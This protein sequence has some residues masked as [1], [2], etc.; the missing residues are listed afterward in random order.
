MKIKNSK[1]KKIKIK[2]TSPNIFG[3]LSSEGKQ[4]EWPDIW[5]GYNFYVKSNSCED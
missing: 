3:S 2:N 5:L 1:F 4:T